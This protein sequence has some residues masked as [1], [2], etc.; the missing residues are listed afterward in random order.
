MTKWDWHPQ[1]NLGIFFLFINTDLYRSLQSITMSFKNIFNITIHTS[2]IRCTILITSVWLWLLRNSKYVG[3]LKLRKAN[4]GCHP[5]KV[6]FF[7]VKN[8]IKYKMTV[9]LYITRKSYVTGSVFIFS[10]LCVMNDTHNAFII[11]VWIETI[12]KNAGNYI[13]NYKVMQCK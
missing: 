4:K 7:L 9:L 1:I 2:N 5:L 10:F 12:Q 6:N 11:Y 8:N 13:W 3:H